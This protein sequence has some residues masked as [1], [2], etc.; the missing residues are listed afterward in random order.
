MPPVMSL[1]ALICVV[2]I[3][4]APAAAAPFVPESD[5]QVLERCR[6]RRATPACAGF[7]G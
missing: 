6:S 3:A 7:A 2:L 5:S 4:A 1:R